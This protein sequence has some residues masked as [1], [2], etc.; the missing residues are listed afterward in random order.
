MLLTI[1]VGLICLV[2]IHL[3]LDAYSTRTAYKASRQRLETFAHAYAQNIV[4]NEKGGV[5]FK[6]DT[7]PDNKFNHPRGNLYALVFDGEALLWSS[8]SVRSVGIP[9]I[10][11]DD[12][13]REGAAVFFHGNPQENGNIHLLRQPIL[14][15]DPTMGGQ[16]RVLML[17]VGED[18]T[19]TDVRVRSFKNALW[20]ALAG[21]FIFIL[22]AQTL[23][24][25]WSIRPLQ[26]LMN[27]LKKVRAGQ[28]NSIQ[29]TYP[30]ELSGVASGLN[31]LIHHEANQ[32][33]SY[34]NALANLAHRLKTPLAVINSALEGGLPE[35][36]LK[37]EVRIQARRMSNMV[38]YQLS[39]ASRS[40]RSTFT[41]PQEIE[42]VAMELVQSLEKL[43]HQKKALCEFE[44]EPHITYPMNKGDLQEM[45]GN[46]LENAF[47]WCNKRVLLTVQSNVA[48]QE[49]VISVEDDGQGV[50]ESRIGDIIKRGVRADERVQGH[51]IGLAIVDDILQSYGGTLSIDRSDELGGARFV[52]VLPLL[53]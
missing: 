15:S 19:L 34:R 29:G 27:E 12:G 31:D 8:P 3:T 40:G 28:Q 41:K 2:S 1:V 17:M 37:D 33:Q 21:S 52:I 4:L 50:P 20:S 23:A 11:R 35:E 22:L 14:L 18:G 48:S 5:S 53:V 36:R 30:A 47:K 7:V 44:I 25:R 45:L 46:L 9:D 49:V 32:T 26:N 16:D 38:S 24:A 10:P 39:V 51:G 43:H 6:N 42:P 13:E